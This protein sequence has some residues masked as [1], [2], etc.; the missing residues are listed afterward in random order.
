[1]QNMPPQE[2]WIVENGTTTRYYRSAEQYVRW[3]KKNKHRIQKI[4]Y[5]DFMG[6]NPYW[7]IV[8]TVDW[9]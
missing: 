3:V 9:P 8:P 5:C 4:W 1:M 2:M 6:G 7:A